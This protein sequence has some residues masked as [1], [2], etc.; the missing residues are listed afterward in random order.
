MSALT[1]YESAVAELRNNEEQWRAFESQG[2]CVTLAGPGSG[3]TKVLTTKMARILRE[4]VREPRGVAC[5]TY[6]NECARELVRR[7]HRLGV[8]DRPNVFVGTLHRF[9]LRFVL[10]PL[11]THLGIDVPRP[12]R[13]ASEAERGSALDAAVREI[14]VY[15]RDFKSTFVP[16][17]R[18]ALTRE[19]GR[20][21]WE[22]GDRGL[23]DV[24]LAYERRLRAIGSIDFDDIVLLSVRAIE[25]SAIARQCLRARFPVLFVDEYQDLGLPLHR[26]V[27]VLAFGGGVR[28]FAVGDPDQSIYGFAGARPSLLHELSQRDE[29]ERVELRTNYRSGRRIVAASEHALG[30]E[31]RFRAESPE[32]GEVVI[33]ACPDGLD[34]QVAHAVGTLIPNARRVGK[35]FGDIALLYPTQQEGDALERALRDAAIPYVRLDKGAG[36]RRTPTVQW[37]EELAAWCCGGWKDGTPPVSRLMRTWAELL[38]LATD[39]EAFAARRALVRFAFSNR[40][41]SGAAN[42][43]LQRLRE[44]V[45]ASRLSLLDQDEQ[46]A[47]A[48]LF[49]A[50][51]LEGNLAGLDIGMFAGKSGSP[52]HVVLMNLHTSK[53]TEFS[54]VVLVGMDDGRMPIYLA[55]TADAV[56]EQRRLFFVGVSRAKH[57]VHLLYSGWTKNQYGRRYDLG[58]SPFV[59]ELERKLGP[60]A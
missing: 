29:V 48:E 44:E 19:D 31:R 17:R 16:F 25:R 60:A 20:E 39:Q 22:P 12:I 5:V 52:D 14:G 11:A 13:V 38:S 46:D 34:A 15:A 36:Y 45:L 42:T 2:H 24:C 40:N 50:C 56:A 26:L 55:Q 53:G 6:N 21:G 30:V 9:C 35:R 4:D 43:W 59:V 51:S 57:A 18:N 47:V 41:P 23:T 8:A 1:G 54:T 49:A 37:I 58:P 32:D 10:R 7:L 27:N 28:L 3:K 33:T